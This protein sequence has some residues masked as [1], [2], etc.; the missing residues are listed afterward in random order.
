MQ[1]LPFRK[2]YQQSAAQSTKRQ[3]LDI[4]IILLTTFFDTD[5]LWQALMIRKKYAEFNDICM[6]IFYSSILFSGA[7]VNPSIYIGERR[8]D[9]FFVILFLYFI[10][11]FIYAGVIVTSTIPPRDL[12][13]I[14]HTKGER[15]R[16]Y[17][18][19]RNRSSKP[20]IFF[21]VRQEQ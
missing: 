1:S 7:K 18:E 6:F 8:Q 4:Q 12:I 14:L 5:H 10:Y 16:L 20:K 13:L 11:V 19:D 21:S 3:H 9:L 17:T 2:C 15:T